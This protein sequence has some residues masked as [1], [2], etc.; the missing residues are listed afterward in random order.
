MGEKIG[1]WHSGGIPRNALKFK[2]FSPRISECWRVHVT[3][4]AHEIARVVRLT[5]LDKAPPVP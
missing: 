3:R 2:D 1:N 5:F 4:L